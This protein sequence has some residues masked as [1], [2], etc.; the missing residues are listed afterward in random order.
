METNLL[1]HVKGA[2]TGATSAR[3]GLFMAADGGTVFFDEIGT[4]RPE[5]QNKLLR[6]MQER[7]FMPVGSTESVT[8]DVRILAATNGD[9]KALV[10]SG[11]FREDLYYRLNVLRVQLPALRERL[12]DIG[13]L[14]DHFLRK[15]AL[16]HD[17]RLEGFEPAAL[18]ALAAYHW[19]GNVR[20][21]ENAVIQGVV[22]ARGPVLRLAD[23]PA[24]LRSGAEARGP[25][26]RPLLEKSTLVEAMAAYE[27][28]LIAEAMAQAGGVQR[29]AARILGVRPTTLNEKIKR[30]GLKGGP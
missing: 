16:E 22:L 12:E 20:E 9:L 10:E 28:R 17:K 15:Y 14:A 11:E 30:L 24:E 19:P 7:T 13:P 5:L 6:V 8:V 26:S 27:R 29:Q 3:E 1:G 4:L 21:L 18:E 2:F 25:A 23:L